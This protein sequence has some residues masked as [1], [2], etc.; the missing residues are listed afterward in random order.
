MVPQ[1][2]LNLPSMTFLVRFIRKPADAGGYLIRS[3]QEPASQD[4]IV[5]WVVRW[6]YTV[7]GQEI[8]LAVHPCQRARPTRGG[9]LEKSHLRDGR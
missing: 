2:G 4:R 3:Y 6:D 1:Q 8:I 7:T 9:A 5:G